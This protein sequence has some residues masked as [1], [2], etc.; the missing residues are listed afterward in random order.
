MALVRSKE[1]ESVLCKV[2]RRAHCSDTLKELQLL[3]LTGEAL[4][5]Q[6]FTGWDPSPGLIRGKALGAWDR[7]LE[8]SQRGPDPQSS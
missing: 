6:V 3:M 4:S 7:T 8:S 2:D 5:A 1:M